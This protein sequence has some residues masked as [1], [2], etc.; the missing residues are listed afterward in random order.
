[1][2]LEEAPEDDE[3][4]F[5]GECQATYTDDEKRGEFHNIRYMYSC[6]CV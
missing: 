1:V 6:V 4:F 5:C 2:G 3:D